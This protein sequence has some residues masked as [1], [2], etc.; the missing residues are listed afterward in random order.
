VAH[1]WVKNQRPGASQ[2]CIGVAKSEERADAATFT[3]SR[4]I[5][6]ASSML[7]QGSSY[8]TG[9]PADKLI[10]NILRLRLDRPPYRR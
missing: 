8:Y 6:T 9:V 1:Q 5:S 7:V 3:P 4:A 10:G 2:H